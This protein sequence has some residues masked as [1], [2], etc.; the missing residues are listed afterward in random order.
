[1][2]KF[3]PAE[4]WGYLAPPHRLMSLPLTGCTQWWRWRCGSLWRSGPSPT[5]E[6]SWCS[7]SPCWGSAARAAR[8]PPTPTRHGLQVTKWLYW[9]ECLMMKAVLIWASRLDQE[10]HH[11][12]LINRKVRARE[13]HR[14]KMRSTSFK[15]VILLPFYPLSDHYHPLWTPAE[16]L[17][18]INYPKPS[19]DAPDSIFSPLS[20]SC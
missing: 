5:S 16:Q 10:K 1:M 18:M 14:E 19:Q 8:L 17:L 13:Q 7:E 2:D 20:A 6:R 11:E 9:L 15:R 3:T 4:C 12:K